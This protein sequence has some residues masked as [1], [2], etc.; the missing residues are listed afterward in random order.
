LLARTLEQGQGLMGQG[1]GPRCQGQ[2]LDSQWQGRTRTS[3]FELVRY[4]RLGEAFVA[5]TG[6]AVLDNV[7]F[8]DKRVQCSLSLTSWLC[9]CLRVLRIGLLVYTLEMPKKFITN[10]R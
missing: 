3:E 2:G 10:Y 6:G 1:P 8:R 4:Q 5:H 9:I 7:W